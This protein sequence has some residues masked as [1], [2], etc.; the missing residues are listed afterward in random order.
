MTPL[1]SIS[2][3]Q[4]VPLLLASIALE[5]L[6]LA[7]I[8]NAE[9]EKLQFVLGTL[10]DTG[11]AFS[12]SEVSLE[13]LFAI[14]ASVRGT[15]R[16]VIKKEML[17]GFKFENVLDLFPI[18][19]TQI[20]AIGGEIQGGVAT[21]NVDIFFCEQNTWEPRAS[22]P[23]P[24]EASAGGLLPNGLVI[25]SHGF[26][27]AP[28]NATSTALF[29]N[30]TTNTWTPAPSANVPRGSLGGDVLNGIFY[31]VGG[32]V[33]LAP[34]NQLA[35][36][37][38]FN[39]TTWSL[40]APLPSARSE[41]VVVS[42]NGLLHAIGGDDGTV[43][44][45]NHDADDPNSNTWT[46]RA[47][48]PQPRAFPSAAVFDGKIYVFGGR[49]PGNTPTND[50]FIYDPTTNTWS[51]GTSMPTSRWGTAACV[52]GAEIFV[53]GGFIPPSQY[54]NIVEAYNPVT[55]TWRTNVVAMPNA[56]ALFP[57]VSF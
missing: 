47:P 52:C 11:V 45:T 26:I 15:I 17:L 51:I 8:M 31:A 18:R 37:E 21:N 44:L 29:F 38:A 16:N 55:D 5:E 24:R 2:I 22:L 48:L 6:S 36:V 35:T 33:G 49:A 12:P 23:Q 10:D 42:L 43:E 54:L 30:P 50:V 27:N 28:F 34:G 9:A 40:V 32:N 4:T 19:P 46:P 56:R 25:V 14:N 39:G 1:I 41:L 57:C 20:L 53:M 7:H 13:D 3:G